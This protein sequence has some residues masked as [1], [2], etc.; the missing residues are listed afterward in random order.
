MAT[1]DTTPRVSTLFHCVWFSNTCPS[2]ERLQRPTAQ[3]QCY[4]SIGRS[5]CC[6][7]VEVSIHCVW[8][9]NTCPSPER[10]QRPTAQGQCHR[11]IGG[12]VCCYCVEVSIHCVWFSNTCPSPERLQRPTAQGQCH[13]SMVDHYLSTCQYYAALHKWATLILILQLCSNF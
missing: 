9:S 2:P 13:R 5:V 11:S 1:C 6:Y 3:G 4:R 7:C 12:S 8:F 10:L